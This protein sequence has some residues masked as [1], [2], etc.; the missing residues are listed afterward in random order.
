MKLAD[1][2]GV[3][4]PASDVARVLMAIAQQV[5]CERR[6]WGTYHYT[7]KEAVSRQKL[8]TMIIEEVNKYRTEPQQEMSPE[9][10]LAP[11][12]RPLNLQLNCQ[13]ILENFGVQQRPWREELERVV[14]SLSEM[15]AA[16]PVV[17]QSMS[18]FRALGR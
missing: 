14:A 12:P 4:T 18:F 11:A 7:A 8:L 1:Q 15:S 5:S 10:E 3:P 2:V 16:D 6:N 17:E 9:P 13:K